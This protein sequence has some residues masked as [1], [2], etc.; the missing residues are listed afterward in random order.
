MLNGVISGYNKSIRQKIQRVNNPKCAGCSKPR[1]PCFFQQK[2]VSRWVLKTWMFPKI[3]VGPQN[4]W[5]I[6]EKLKSLLKLMI[7]GYH[8][9]NGKVEKPIKI[10][11][12]GLPLFWKHQHPTL[13]KSQR[14]LHNTTKNPTPKSFRSM[15]I[16]SNYIS[17]DPF[18]VFLQRICNPNPFTKFPYP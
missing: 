2:K 14:I 18:S 4:G 11:D 5:F 9:F 15:V 13:S 6:M 17:S 1:R 8:Y 12:L 3:G 16:A 10:D 7:W